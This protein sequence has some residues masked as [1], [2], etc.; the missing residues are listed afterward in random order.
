MQTLGTSCLYTTNLDN[1]IVPVC[2]SSL[3]LTLILASCTLFYNMFS[4]PL[5]LFF[6][7]FISCVCI[8][9]LHLWYT[10]LQ[11]MLISGFQIYFALYI[12]F[13]LLTS[14]FSQ[15]CTHVFISSIYNE[16]LALSTIKLCSPLLIFMA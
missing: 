9:Y 14:M 13:N 2:F 16:S 3:A 7:F 15:K 11:F 6:F 1:C 5:F 10:H 12:K 4:Y 8:D